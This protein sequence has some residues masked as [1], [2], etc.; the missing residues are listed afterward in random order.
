M[1]DFYT[2]IKCEFCWYIYITESIMNMYIVVYL[3]FHS[4][5]KHLCNLFFFSKFLSDFYEVHFEIIVCIF[6][7]EFDILWKI[8]HKLCLKITMPGSEN[9][10]FNLALYYFFIHGTKTTSGIKLTSTNSLYKGATIWFS[11]RQ[12][13]IQ[14]EIAQP[15]CLKIVRASIKNLRESW[16]IPLILNYIEKI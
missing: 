9:C 13:W 10:S 8:T 5:S 11:C 16:C 2:E 7:C 6:Y 15:N 3:L 12:T 4:N 14:F 1:S